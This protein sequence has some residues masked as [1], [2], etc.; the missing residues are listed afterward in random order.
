MVKVKSA[1]DIKT[2][3]T[4]AAALVPTRYK[5]GVQSAT[6][7]AEALAGQDLYTARMSDPT[8][9]AR[10]SRGISK[11]SDQQWKDGAISKGAPIIGARM[12]AAADKQVA[13]W[14]PYGNALSALTLPP[15][16][17]DPMTNLTQRAGAVVRAM[18]DTKNAQSS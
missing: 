2:N 14:A 13:N 15:K 11:V 3:Y 1:A 12:T 7:Q 17:A 6:W 5:Q 16:V 4:A 8:V 18:V 10:R 9:L